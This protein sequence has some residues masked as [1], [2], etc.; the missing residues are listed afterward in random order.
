MSLGVLR[1]PSSVRGYSAPPPIQATL[2][3][4]VN[5]NSDQG[6]DASHDGLANLLSLAKTNASSNAI[7]HQVAA[8]PADKSPEST[9]PIRGDQQS[10]QS[11]SSQLGNNLSDESENESSSSS[12]GRICS[13]LEGATKK[14]S[15]T[16]HQSE[17]QRHRVI[18][19]AQVRA[20]G[21][22]STSKK[23]ESSKSKA[24][25]FYSQDKPKRQKAAPAVQE[26]KKRKE[27]HVDLLKKD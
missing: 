11:P 16:L 7:E 4:N 24:N 9:T 2:R 19:P 26:K 18:S 10:R 12:S 6:K 15:A 5:V 27:S 23:T 17:S 13:Y 8:G 14:R 1:N 25:N 3:P 21:I 22:S 20:K